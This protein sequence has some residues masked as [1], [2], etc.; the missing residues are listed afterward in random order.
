MFQFLRGIVLI[1]AVF[2]IAVFNGAA[3]GQTITLVCSGKMY[4]SEPDKIESTV[5]P[6][7][8]TL[9]LELK[10]VSTPVG[11]FRITKVEDTKISFDDPEKQLKVFGYLD[12]LSGQMTVFWRRPEEEAKMQAG[13]ISK[14]VM[15]AELSCSV[16]KRLF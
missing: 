7:A 5:G 3:L 16:S 11:D 8:A 6:G 12:R 1:A 10:R 14:M 9:N 15:Y 13:L 2:T 4:E